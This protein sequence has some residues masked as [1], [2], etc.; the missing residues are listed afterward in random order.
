MSGLRLY[1]AP[2]NLNKA[3]KQPKKSKRKHLIPFHSHHA[4]GLQLHKTTGPQANAAL[5]QKLRRSRYEVS[6]QVRRKRSGR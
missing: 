2:P 1:E 3:T 5:S 4:P 6:S